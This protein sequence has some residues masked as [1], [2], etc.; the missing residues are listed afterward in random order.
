MENYYILRDRLFPEFAPPMVIQP[1]SSLRERFLATLSSPEVMLFLLLFVS[2]AWFGHSNPGWNVNSRLALSAAWATTGSPQVDQFVTRF[3]TRDLS[4]Y[5]GRLYSDKS[6]GTSLLGVPAAF[7][8][9]AI[10]T[11]RGE[12]FSTRTYTY[13]ITLGSVVP[14]TALAGVLLM[15]WLALL[16]PRASRPSL[17]LI[18]AGVIMGSLLFLYGTLFMSYGPATLFLLA[19]LITVEKASAMIDQDRE[20]SAILKL[21]ALAGLFGGLTIMCEYLYAAAIGLT[22]LYLLA[23]CGRRHFIPAAL[24]YGAGCVL[25]NSPF[26]IYSTMIFGHPSIPYEFHLVPEFR[27]AMSIG[28]MGATWPPK[29]PVLW[30]TT[31]HPFR[32]LFFYSPM[33]FIGAAGLITMIT[34]KDRA[35]RFVAILC[36]ASALFYIL[37]NASY[38]MWWGGWSFSPRHLAPAIP[39]LAAG[40]G[41]WLSNPWVRPLI[42]FTGII[43]IGVHLLVNAVEPQVPDGGWQMALL[44]PSLIEYDYPNTFGRQIAPWLA[45]DKLD[46]NLGITLGISGIL[47]LLPLIG[48]WVLWGWLF[49]RS[50]Y[51][52]TK[53]GRPN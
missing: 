20:Q 44:A 16:W 1:P 10:E 26:L 38:Y 50:N 49:W 30:L 52:P 53:T 13:L 22:G 12:P 32:G 42:L 11:S 33:L 24:L 43:G 31:F 21:T 28:L 4:I 2:L 37:F 51:A 27:Y 15:R 40:L 14:A 17:A 46:W 8:V 48:L 25:G 39:F 29:A 41:L 3:E 47:S 7:I 6:I 36:A 18:S 34:Q 23:R 9:N 35:R 45:N 5:E 19:T